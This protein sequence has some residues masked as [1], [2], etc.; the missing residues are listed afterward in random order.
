MPFCHIPDGKEVTAKQAM[1]DH[2]HFVM[3]EKKDPYSTSIVK[4]NR[5]PS[6]SPNSRRRKN[7]RSTRRTRRN[8]RSTR[9]NRK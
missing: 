2:C 6:P 1:E 3:K 8:R 5:S 9:R 7:R 4:I